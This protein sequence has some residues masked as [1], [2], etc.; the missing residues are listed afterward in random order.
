MVRRVALAQSE[1]SRGRRFR[2][3]VDV[4][5]TFT[6]VVLVEEESGEVLIAKVATVPAD[7]SQGCIDGIDKALDAFAIDPAEV[8]FIVHGTTIATNTI[9]EGKGA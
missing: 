3:G 6:D 5:G 1:N 8:A 7:P 9:I 2:V 4:G